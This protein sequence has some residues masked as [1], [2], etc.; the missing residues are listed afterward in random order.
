MFTNFL[1]PYF[2]RIFFLCC[3]LVL[4][5]LGKI[6]INYWLLVL[7][8]I[9]FYYFCFWDIVRRWWIQRTQTEILSF[10]YFT[11]MFMGGVFSRDI[12]FDLKGWGPG[13]SARRV[14]KHLFWLLVFIL[15]FVFDFRLPLTSTFYSHIAT[16]YIATETFIYTPPD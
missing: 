5:V 11:W 1:Y 13:L 8:P 9:P 2:I 7:L 16:K 12:L 6:V 3:N 14:I 15:I 10:L 4:Q